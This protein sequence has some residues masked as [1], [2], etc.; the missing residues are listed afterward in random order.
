[1][2]YNNFNTFLKNFPKK[3]VLFNVN[4]IVKKNL[5]SDHIFF[6]YHRYQPTSV[7]WKL[8]TVQDV[9]IVLN[10]YS[11]VLYQRK[12]C[13]LKVSLEYLDNKITLFEAMNVIVIRK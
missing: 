5:N 13:F 11:L 4:N 7:D 12:K 2:Y 10:Y 3:L 9:K 6:H 1:M 8:P